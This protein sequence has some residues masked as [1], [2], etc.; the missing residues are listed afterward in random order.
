MTP[1][2]PERPKWPPYLR[3]EHRNETQSQ[4]TNHGKSR[5]Q[6]VGKHSNETSLLPENGDFLFKNDD[7]LLKNDHFYANAGT[8]L[9]CSSPLR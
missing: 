3:Q 2:R 9:W 4:S 8:M 5:Q 1:R 7:L 6:K